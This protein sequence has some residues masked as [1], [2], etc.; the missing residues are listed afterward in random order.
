MN[1]NSANKVVPKKK[2]N[3]PN[4]KKR[5]STQKGKSMNK[6]AQLYRVNQNVANSSVRKALGA[7]SIFSAQVFPSKSR[8]AAIVESL[9]MP[10]DFPP[11]RYSQDIGTVRTASVHPYER[12]SVTF[13]FSKAIGSN[14]ELVQLPGSGFAA[15]F[16]DPFR[17]SI[18]YHPYLNQTPWS[19][20]AD[21]RITMAGNGP[22]VA[23]KTPAVALPLV[24]TPSF[25]P[26]GPVMYPGCVAGEL[27][28]GWYWKQ[29]GDDIR[30]SWTGVTAAP[31]STV[32]RW[33]C[34]DPLIANKTL[35]AET[36]TLNGNN[37]YLLSF[38]VTG[39]VA[40]GYITYDLVV[41]PGATGTEI[42]YTLSVQHTSTGA[43]DIYCHRATADISKVLATT[44]D[45]R[46]LAASLMF[47]NTTP[48]QY[49]G[50]Q[51]A[52]KQVPKS[53]PWTDYVLTGDPYANISSLSDSYSDVAD[54]GCYGFLKIAETEDTEL[55]SQSKQGA[56]NTIPGGFFYLDT[57][58]EYLVL[59][60]SQNAGYP[61]GYYTFCDGIEFVCN[62]QWRECL[63]PNTTVA[64]WNMA[65]S[66]ITKTPQ[67]H[68][69]F[70]HI[71]EIISFLRGA[72]KGAASAV[73]Q[74]GPA[75]SE[76]A[77]QLARAL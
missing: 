50:G 22:N 53:R 35:I 69:N 77:G 23:L 46:Q 42:V 60:T 34:W 24:G 37:N 27:D 26:H 65:L 39:V 52:M 48:K 29:N 64:D 71:M 63:L 49:I 32:I 16:R 70:I 20:A 47:T 14:K 58:A 17:S 67:Y 75:V 59:G 40:G 61:A 36:G 62:D 38:D 43:A 12:V 15:K 28:R 76:L 3:R 68:K 6:E 44:G 19:Y 13:A 10:V 2:K 33:Y 41:V 73:A 72:I 18:H 51:L 21:Y 66:I 25:A 30:L 31:A 45:M 56:L 54:D 7:D 1:N 5:D 11:V 55:F 57:D 4:K 8:V 9:T 74:Y